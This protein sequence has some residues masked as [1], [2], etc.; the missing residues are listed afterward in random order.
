MVPRVIEK[1]CNHNVCVFRSA[2][3]RL[4]GLRPQNRYS[5]YAR[6][7]QEGDSSMKLPDVCVCLII[8]YFL[9]FFIQ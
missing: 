9:F 3:R 6:D 4:L 1:H 5:R 2:L 7:T 8:F